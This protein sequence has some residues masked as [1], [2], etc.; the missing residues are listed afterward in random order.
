MIEAETGNWVKTET[1][2]NYVFNKNLKVQLSM[3]KVQILS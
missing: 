2:F 1:K 3:R